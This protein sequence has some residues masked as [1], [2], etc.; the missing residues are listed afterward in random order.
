MTMVWVPIS[1]PGPW[2][3]LAGSWAVLQ[4]HS[5]LVESTDQNVQ[6]RAGCGHLDFVSGFDAN[7]P[8]ERTY[9]VQVCLQVFW[10]TWD[11]IVLDWK[12]SSTPLSLGW[13]K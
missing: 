3:P 8:P 5:L 11:G 7:L 2:T 13:S 9:E 10:L 1:L 6:C 4:W 12:P